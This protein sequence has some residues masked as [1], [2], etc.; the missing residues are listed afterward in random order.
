MQYSTYC[1]LAGKPQGKPISLPT[2]DDITAKIESILD[3]E[4]E[5]FSLC[6]DALVAGKKQTALANTASLPAF[7]SRDVL[8]AA[9]KESGIASLFR[10][11]KKGGVVSGE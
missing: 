7:G 6:R 4:F 2:M 3:Y 1:N 10:V 9:A 8:A 11:S 5:S